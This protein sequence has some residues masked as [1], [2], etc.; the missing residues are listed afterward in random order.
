MGVITVK[1]KVGEYLVRD[2]LLYTKTDEWVKI[3]NDLVTIGITDYA[4]KKLR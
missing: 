3:E 1:T 2:D 4:Q